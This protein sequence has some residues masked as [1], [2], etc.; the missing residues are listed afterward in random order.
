MNN[1]LL[2]VLREVRKFPITYGVGIGVG[3]YIFFASKKE[4]KE[5]VVS[6]NIVNN[7]QAAL[8]VP[9]GRHALRYTLTNDNASTIS[10]V[11]NRTLDAEIS[12][13]VKLPGKGWRV[14]S[15]GDVV[16]RDEDGNWSIE[17]AE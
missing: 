15:V 6:Y 16:V 9:E 10:D 11:I 7:H 14:A 13:R 12:V 1:T 4:E 2:N 8:Y 5:P 3:L 17:K